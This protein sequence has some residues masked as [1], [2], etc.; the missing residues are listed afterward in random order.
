MKHAAGRI[1][2]DAAEEEQAP[3]DASAR[4]SATGESAV[5]S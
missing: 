4:R 1:A 3:A 5:R 2:A